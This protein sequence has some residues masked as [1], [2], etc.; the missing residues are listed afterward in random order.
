MYL[1]TDFDLEQILSKNVILGTFKLKKR[2]YQS[3]GFNPSSIDDP[4]YYL[5]T[6]AGRY[7]RLNNDIYHDI[8]NGKMKI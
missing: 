6:R 7:F 4:I 5:D 2:T 3:E 1:I 8:C